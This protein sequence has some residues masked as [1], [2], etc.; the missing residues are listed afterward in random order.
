MT[1]EPNFY[2]AQKD[3]LW[4]FYAKQSIAWNVVRPS[5]ILGA[6]PDAAECMSASRYLRSGMR[7]PQRAAGV[8]VRPDRLGEYQVP[9]QRDAECISDGVG[10]A[11]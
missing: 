7:A 2:Y 11:N 10:C 1:L 3:Y 9:E 4:D 8:P 5:F 6:V